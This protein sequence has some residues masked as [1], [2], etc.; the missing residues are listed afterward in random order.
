[1]ATKGNEEN[2]EEIK[3][4]M[5]DNGLKTVDI[6]SGSEPHT[7][8]DIDH[9]AQFMCE[10]MD[11]YPKL[12]EEVKRLI[13]PFIKTVEKCKKCMFMEDAFLECEKKLPAYLDKNNSSYEALVKGH[14]TLQ[15]ENIMYTY[16]ANTWMPSL[17]LRC[18]VDI[19]GNDG[20]EPVFRCHHVEIVKGKEEAAQ[21]NKE[22]ESKQNSNSDV[23][24]KGVVN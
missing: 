16:I 17:I 11:F 2:I 12:C 21:M 4:T 13:S 8:E 7:D 1:M 20:I 3:N 9:V 23:C 22:A 10:I 6:T 24:S 15:Q 14:L 5:K 18:F 19:F